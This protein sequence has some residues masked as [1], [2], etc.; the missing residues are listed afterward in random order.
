[1][2]SDV[3]PLSK[4]DIEF[5]QELQLE[6]RTQPNDG[7]ADPVFWAVGENFREYG[8]A[9]AYADGIEE[10]EDCEGDTYKVGFKNFH[11]C[12]EGTVFLTKRA[13][14]KHIEQNDYHYD[15]P[16]TYALTAWRNPE[17]EHLLKILKNADWNA[18][19]EDNA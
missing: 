3:K 9:T 10:K 5:L 6:L 13:C 16:H 11:R 4:E 2:K 12:R 14:K 18:L 8:Y 1:M 17:V 7:N 19:K 15:N